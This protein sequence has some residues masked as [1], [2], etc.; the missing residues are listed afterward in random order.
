MRARTLLSIILP[1]ISLISGCSSRLYQD[2]ILWRAKLNHKA[3]DEV[4]SEKRPKTIQEIRSFLGKE[5][6]YLPEKKERWFSAKKSVELGF[7]DC[8]DI[9]FVGAYFAER[10]GYPPK[11]LILFGN[12]DPKKPGS[13]AVTLLE[14]QLEDKNP[15]I[16]YGAIEK[17]DLFHP[18]YDSI[19]S[20]VN[21]INRLYHMDYS[22]YL[23]LNLND[24]NKD[25]RTTDKSLIDS[26]EIKDFY[27]TELENKSGADKA[28]VEPEKLYI[29]KYRVGKSLIFY[30]E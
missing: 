3:W 28:G 26:G 20:L 27:L 4:N 10:L 22:H 14:E 6:L 23:V 13:H 15:E 11:I 16:K 18:I 12:S 24:I 17:A 29:E 1:A 30:K 7:G 2:D 5:M 19:N 25:W 8:E 9:A 21:D